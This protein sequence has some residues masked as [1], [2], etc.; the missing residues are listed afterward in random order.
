MA[1]GLPVVLLASSRPRGN[2]FALA[3][4]AFVEDQVR[5]IDLG[6]H[7]IAYYDYEPARDDDFIALVRT[8]IDAPLWILA[9]PLYWYTMSAQAKTFIDRLS[10]LLERHRDLG[11]ALRGKG[12]AVVCSGT[13]A[14]LPSGFD[15]PFVL[16]CN[17]LGMRYLGSHYGRFTGDAFALP[18]TAADAAAF[19]RQVEA[20]CR[21]DTR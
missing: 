17:Y 13:D 5:L 18:D 20:D 16:T 14:Q 19:G 2:T 10:D 7:R 15:E 6:R 21:S 3:R 8:I 12:F 1:S 11:H 4:L 9:T